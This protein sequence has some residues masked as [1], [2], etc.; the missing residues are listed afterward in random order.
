MEITIKDQIAE[1]EIKFTKAMSNPST[2][3]MTIDGEEFV[4]N[5]KELEAVVIAFN[6]VNEV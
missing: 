1:D 2:I 5:L 6:K 3:V 4:L